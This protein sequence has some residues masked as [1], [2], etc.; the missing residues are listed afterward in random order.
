MAGAP[1]RAA[2]PRQI[3]SERPAAPQDALRIAA[4][5]VPRPSGGAKACAQITYLTWT[6][7]NLLR[8]TVYVG[9]REDKLA[10]QGGE[11]D[12]NGRA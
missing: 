4:R 7:D 8:H 2:E 1:P 11:S 6:A 12:R 3:A 5:S 9:L 10:D